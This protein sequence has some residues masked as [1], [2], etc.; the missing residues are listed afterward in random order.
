VTRPSS[1]A[2]QPGAYRGDIDGLRA[3]AILLVVVFHGFPKLLPGGYLGVDVFFVISGYLITDLVARSSARGGRGL[4]DFYARRVRRLFPGLILMT[5]ASLV[6]GWFAL[7][8]DEYALLGKH[9]WSAA[10][11]IPNFALWM[12]AGYWDTASALKPLM[13]LW[14]I[15]VEEQFYLVW[16][17][18]LLLLLKHG[19]SPRRWAI[20]LFL[21]SF[22]AS[23]V[24]AAES[25]TAAF[26][27]A[28]FRMWELMLGGALAGAVGLERDS[29][30]VASSDCDPPGRRG[31]VEAGG[32]LR[33]NLQSLVGL[34]L[35]VSAAAVFEGD[36]GYSAWNTL[37]PVVGTAMIL[38]AG[39]T[40]AF[41]RV[42]LGNRAM[43]F[44]GKVSYP[45]YLWHWPLL[46]FVAIVESGSAPPQWRLGLLAFS[47]LLAILT[48]RLVEI[49][50]RSLKGFR[51]V[52]TLLALYLL[53]GAAGAA[54]HANKGFP[55]RIA[56]LAAQLDAFE[57]ESKGLYVR[58]DCSRL[59]GVPTRCLSN[60]KPHNVAV[61][62]DSFSTNTFFVLEEFYRGSDTGVLRLG[63]QGCL[64][65]YDVERYIYRTSARCRERM[66]LA[67]DYVLKDEHFR[68][69]VFSLR[70]SL[71]IDTAGGNRL[72]L[73]DETKPS[74]N[75]DVFRSAMEV[76][77][78][79]FVDAGKDVIF[80]LEWPELE[81]DPKTCVDVRPFRFHP[82]VTTTCAIDRAK[83]DA[84]ESLAR[85]VI[86][87]TLA[88]FP[89]TSYW[90]PRKILCDD[91]YC[92]AMKDG[93]MLYRDDHH[94]SLIGSEYLAKRFV[95]EKLPRE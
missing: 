72:V 56:T 45:W 27:L 3:I 48:Y 40:S 67:L 60:G 86:L 82:F 52:G 12:E 57:W 22:A 61:V 88:K 24:V 28:P 68:T 54:V 83:S 71:Y 63:K 49:P 6:F 36:A 25:P 20:P 17:G 31:L 33:R 85:E 1:D 19:I 95:T 80:A 53:V 77:L 37:V 41:N 66:R 47:L 9:T 64:P 84:R 79:R 59:A 65:F 50:I 38:A 4:A 14:S 2:D 44:V 93:V 81:F 73:G 13:H 74:H 8:P 32:G 51:G 16:P 94:L 10:L 39:P 58:D 35:I 55:H 70:E 15:G 42:M 21:A 92:W 87:E 91:L 5:T 7:L 89:R 69:V 26:Y 34:I 90:D 62:G 43:T 11:F 78:Q 30:L 23:I 75:A 29:S 76:T 46:S 18:M